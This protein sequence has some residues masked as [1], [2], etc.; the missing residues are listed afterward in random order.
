VGKEL[1]DIQGELAKEIAQ[2]F[3]KNFD[4]KQKD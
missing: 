1:R 4:A 2:N 3:L